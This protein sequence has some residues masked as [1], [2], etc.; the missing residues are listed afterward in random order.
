VAE[1]AS[2]NIVG[3][4]YAWWLNEL[5]RAF[6][7]RRPGAQAWRTLARHTSEGL[8]IF[9]RSGAAIKTLG[10][11]PSDAG[12]SQIAM[13]KKVVAQKAAVGADQVLLRMSPADVV[14]RT[15]QIPKAASDVIEPVLQNQM[16]RIVPWSSDDTRYGYRI[17]GQNAAAPDQLDIQIAATTRSMLESARQRA[18][19]LGLSPYAVDFAPDVTAD[20]ASIELQLLAPDPVKQMAWT[21][22]TGIALLLAACLMIGAFGLYLMWNRQVESDD[23]EA[24]IATARSSVEEVK[25]LNEENS[26]LRQQRERLV[27]RKSEE[28]AVMVL[29]EAMSR[30]LPDA[31]YLTELEIHGR[32]ARIA[33][34]SD[35]PTALI[36][37]LE[38]TP[39]FEDVRFSAPTTREEGETAGTFSIISRAQGGPK[40]ERKP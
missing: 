5:A 40:L 12:P 37:M 8:E 26:E 28:P 27:R 10:T 32:D 19:S 39:Q 23:L 21:L 36:T 29:I 7:P 9:T 6:A 11:L 33:G 31:A 24:R 30:A 17:V 1:N 34:K 25:R 16:E 20:A 2:T 3:R 22:Q 18:E 4:F 13:M 38:A 35:D 15:I 14:E